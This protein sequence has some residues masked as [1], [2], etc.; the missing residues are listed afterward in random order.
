V[1]S[2]DENTE[3]EQTSGEGSPCSVTQLEKLTAA[4]GKNVTDY[5]KTNSATTITKLSQNRVVT[6]CSR[7]MNHYDYFQKMPRSMKIII[8]TNFHL[9]Q[10]CH[11]S[12]IHQSNQI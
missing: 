1:S 6:Y 8:V 7:Q 10:I 4:L 12:G 5:W 9:H 2:G 3:A 11:F